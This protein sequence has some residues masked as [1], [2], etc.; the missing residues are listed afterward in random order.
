VFV[1][2]GAEAAIDHPSDIKGLWHYFYMS[3]NNGVAV[4]WRYDGE[5]WAR[6]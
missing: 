4:G 6:V 1:A 3:F 5:S 2:Q